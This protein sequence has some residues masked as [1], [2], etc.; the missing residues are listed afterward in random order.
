MSMAS[1]I[2]GQ[3]LSCPTSLPRITG[4]RT[5]RPL[6]R[7]P[8]AALHVGLTMLQRRATPSSP[9][10]VALPG[11]RE[12]QHNAVE[13]DAATSVRFQATGPRSGPPSRVSTTRSRIVVGQTAGKRIAARSKGGRGGWRRWRR[14][15]G[16]TD[17][18]GHSGV[19]RTAG[20]IMRVR[21][22]A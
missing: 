11:R 4:L 1:Q 21:R 22:I 13:N 3:G 5:M 17:D 6:K 12:H 15:S 14:T 7:T 20:G 16:R 10:P 18:V 8:R 19:D 2:S 9:S